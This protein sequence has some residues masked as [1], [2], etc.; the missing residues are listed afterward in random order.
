MPGYFQRKGEPSFLAQLRQGLR[1]AR[2]FGTI[3][4]RSD[5]DDRG[6]VTG[7]AAL[8]AGL[9]MLRCLR[10]SRLHMEKP[11]KSPAIAPRSVSPLLRQDDIVGVIFVGKNQGRNRLPKSRSNW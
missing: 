8:E 2:R 10:G 6:S 7:R 4:S 9:S 11:Q 5:P 3:S 1:P